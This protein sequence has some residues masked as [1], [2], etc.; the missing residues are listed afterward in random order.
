MHWLWRLL[1]LTNASGWQYLWWSGFAADIPIF[2]MSWTLYRRHNCHTP[3]CWRIARHRI[4]GTNYVV[5]ARH[6]PDDKPGYTTE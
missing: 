1:G 5:C 3:G 6:H 4:D 2:G